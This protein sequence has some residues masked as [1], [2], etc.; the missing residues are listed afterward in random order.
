LLDAMAG[1][2][3]APTPDTFIFWEGLKDYL[4]AKG[5]PSAEAVKTAQAALGLP[6]T[7]GWDGDT[8]AGIVNIQLTYG[9][10]PTGLP[11]SQ[12]LAKIASVIGGAGG[13]GKKKKKDSTS[14]IVTLAVLA[15][16]FKF[17]FRGE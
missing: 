14:D 11:D 3:A 12:T 8:A 10:S 17:L 9:L 16:A 4:I 13:G 1:Q 7:G 15:L 6:T 5:A 2:Y